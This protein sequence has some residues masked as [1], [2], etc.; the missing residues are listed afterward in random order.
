LSHVIIDTDPGIDDA[1]ALILAT[2][3]PELRVEAV[4]TVVGN[5]S[6]DKAHLNALKILDFMDARG[7]PVARG[8]PKPLLREASHAEEI[9]GR[10]GLGEAVL[11]E[12]K[13]GSCEASAV[14]L[15][16]DKARE[17][18][19]EL[20]IIALGPLTN[21]ASAILAEPGLASMVGGIVLMGGAYHL[22]PYGHGNVTPVAEF[23]IWHDPEAAKI[24]FESGIQ[25]RAVG[26]DITSDPSNSLGP[27]LF[28]EIEG[29]GTRRSRLVAD[30]CRGLMRR[31]GSVQ[32]HDP[33]AVAVASKPELAETRRFFV[34]VE[35]HGLITRGQTVLDRRT[36]GSSMREPNVEVC[37]S[38]ASERF[39][40]LFMDRV[41]H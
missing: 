36:R 33:I 40:E 38:L 21:I 12:P 30:L 27:D 13:M 32:L 16:V 35:T 15:I 37:V 1:L 9:H 18:G 10:S 4:T 5:V 28:R 6:Q 34:E 26:L 3:S 17:L 19:R 24:V 20:T 39:M 2:R 25:L 22:T 23:N 29:L 14:K 7:I 31:F 8:A 41:V 11:P